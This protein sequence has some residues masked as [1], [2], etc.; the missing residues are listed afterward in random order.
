MDS[1]NKNQPEENRQDLRGEQA[2]RKIKEIVNQAE[3]C[4]FCTE[5]SRDGAAARPMNVRQVDDQ[6]N[7]WF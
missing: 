1:I 7:L 5:L 3:N 4:F 2:V 6:G